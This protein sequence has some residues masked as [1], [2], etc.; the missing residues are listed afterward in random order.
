[1]TT[2]DY[3]VHTSQHLEMFSHCR[4]RCIFTVGERTFRGITVVTDWKAISYNS[5]LCESSLLPHI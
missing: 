4:N 1:M 5:S 3:H 2:L